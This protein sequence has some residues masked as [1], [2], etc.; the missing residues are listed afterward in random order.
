MGN[1]TWLMA[2]LNL[3]PDSFYA[4]SRTGADT[5]AIVAA[6]QRAAAEGADL[7]DLGAESSRPGATPLDP[8]A[9]QRRLLPALAAVRRALPQALISVDT[10]H[11]DT[12]AAALEAGA[13][14][15]NDVSGL[16]DAAMGGV[17]ARSHC[18]V[19]LMHHRGEFKT[20]H[21][22]PPL[23][24]PLACVREGLATIVARAAAAGIAGVR[25]M[26]DPG[27]GFGKNLDENFSL[28]DGLACLHEFG[29]PL[30]VGLS[31]KS[32]LRRE[33]SQP[34]EQRLPASLAAAVIAVLAGAH[35]V[36]VHDVEPTRE[37][38][39]LA[40]RLVRALPA[41]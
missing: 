2:V 41:V 12:A 6:A 1:R 9:E 17:L 21:Q 16:E 36:R 24:D 20:M 32:F 3:T 14:V 4:P 37:A 25:L 35:L 11:A 34:P 33:P 40:D 7:L 18:G 26:L 28:L 23:A 5:A 10:R 19:V 22:L 13:D 15:I 38:M 8:A 39:R 31:R 30:L 27:F 29:R